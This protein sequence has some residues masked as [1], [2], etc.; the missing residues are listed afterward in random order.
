MTQK[1]KKVVTDLRS[2]NMGALMHDMTAFADA[3]DE[4]DQRITKLESAAKPSVPP[5]APPAAPVKGQ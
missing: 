5:A 4:V 1:I 3:L 2:G